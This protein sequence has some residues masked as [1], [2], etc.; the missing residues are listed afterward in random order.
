MLDRLHKVRDQLASVAASKADSAV[1]RAPLDLGR[2]LS[3]LALDP[4]DDAGL[5]RLLES[6]EIGQGTPQ[7]LAQ[8]VD[9]VDRLVWEYGLY[10]VP[11]AKIACDEFLARSCALL[12]ETGGDAFPMPGFGGDL[13]TMA[14]QKGLQTQQILTPSQRSGGEIA[15]VVRRALRAPG[16]SP[17]KLV[18]AIST[19]VWTDASEAI[20]AAARAVIK[21]NGIAAKDLRRILWQFVDANPQVETGLLRLAVNRLWEL[22]LPS[23]KEVKKRLLAALEVRGLKM[24]WVPLGSTFDASFSEAM[25]E[26]TPVAARAPARTIVGVL[27]PGFL[28]SRGSAVQKALVAVSTGQTR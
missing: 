21:E 17:S 24:M 18:V 28:D 7:T 23:L 26:S 3:A 27:R 22:E 4:V 20:D 25:F 1:R 12:R 2:T 5:R 19:G 13:L 11:E 14:R 10:N 16:L 6:I 9:L 15:H 8:A